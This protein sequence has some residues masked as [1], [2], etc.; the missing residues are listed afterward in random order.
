MFDFDAEHTDKDDKITDQW[1]CLSDHYATFKVSF[2]VFEE[3]AL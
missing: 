1:K 3:Y 2:R